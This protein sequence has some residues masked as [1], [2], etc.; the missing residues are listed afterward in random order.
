MYYEATFRAAKPTWLDELAIERRIGALKDSFGIRPAR[1]P[2]AEALIGACILEGVDTQF[3][4]VRML[5]SSG[6][7]KALVRSVLE[8]RT[9]PLP[10]HHLWQTDKYGRYHL[11]DLDF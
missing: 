2:R 7:S 3:E 10:G 5:G 6:L 11:L 9:G 8:E 1:R 4:I